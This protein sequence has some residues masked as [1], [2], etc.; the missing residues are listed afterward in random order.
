MNSFGSATFSTSVP[1]RERSTAMLSIVVPCFNEGRN[2]ELLIARL[3]PVLRGLGI[4][5]EVICVDDGSIDETWPTLAILC[6]QDPNLRAMRLSRN[7]GKEAALTA[8]IDVARGDGV[9]LIDADLQHP[10]ELIPALV[11]RWRDGIDMVYAIRTSRAG[12]SWLRQLTTRGFYWMF[13]RLSDVDL[14]RGAGDFRLLDRSVVD[15]LK[16]MP[17]RV[18]FMKG[19]YAWVGFSHAGVEF[20]PSLR[21]TGTS[22]MGLRRLTRFG[23]DGIVAFS[24]LPLIV[25]GWLGALIAVPALAIGMVLLVRTLVYGIDVPGYASTIVAVMVL[26]GVQL[27]MLGLLG[28]YVG[29]LYEETKRRPIY[30]VKEVADDWTP[31]PSPEAMRRG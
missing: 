31:S 15:A 7:F 5:F 17:E 30:I 25:A 8:G 11:A 14:P 6:R 26:G 1:I 13:G 10:P 24:R 4:P 29:R 23:F 12:D 18:R 27:L 16:A 22:T 21:A 3:Q 19:L 9:L 28:A 2:I 20:E